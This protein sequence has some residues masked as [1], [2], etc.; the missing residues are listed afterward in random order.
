MDRWTMKELKETDDISFAIQILYERRKSLNLYSPLY[1][2]IS[3]AVNTLDRI[4][5]AVK[6]F[7][8]TVSEIQNESNS[9]FSDCDES[10]KAK[11]LENA[12]MLDERE[13][14]NDA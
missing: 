2:K 14:M 13:A 3:E 4:R 5:G 6:I 7:A 9:D 8:H 12:R 11:I 10:I 1:Q